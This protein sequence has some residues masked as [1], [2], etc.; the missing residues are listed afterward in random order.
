MA[1]EIVVEEESRFR[2]W[3]VWHLLLSFFA[4]SFTPSIPSIN[5]TA[6]VLSV[7]RHIMRVGRAGNH[8]IT[9]SAYLAMGY[10][11]RSKV[12]SAPGVRVSWRGG[13]RQCFGP[14]ATR[15]RKADIPTS[16][17]ATAGAACCVGSTPKRPRRTQNQLVRVLIP[18]LRCPKMQ[19]LLYLA[20]WHRLQQDTPPRSPRVVCTKPSS[21]RNATQRNATQRS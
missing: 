16:T 2:F 18:P 4:V 10:C 3:D 19:A 21:T 8:Y 6:R 5:V 15:K 12:V 9:I 11:C 17:P 20:V 1:N 14:P 7:L 13:G